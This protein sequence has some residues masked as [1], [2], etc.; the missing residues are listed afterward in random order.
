MHRLTKYEKE[1]ILLT[2]EQDDFWDIYT[3]NA[4]LKRKLREFASKYPELCRL[5][6]QT[7]EGSVTYQVKKDRVS[8]NFKKPI[9]EEARQKRSKAAKERGLGQS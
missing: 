1:T 5:K 3:F 6:A 7:D 9:S 2:N 4:A 8:V